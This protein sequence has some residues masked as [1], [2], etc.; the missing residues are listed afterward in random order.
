MASKVMSMFEAIG[1]FVHDGMSVVMGTALGSGILERNKN[2]YLRNST[3]ALQEGGHQGLSRQVPHDARFTRGELIHEIMPDGVLAVGDA[4]HVKP[5][6]H[7]VDER[8]S[9]MLSSG[10]L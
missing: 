5:E 9:R 4:A 8:V 1:Q 2:I 3:G 6:D 10:L 7:P